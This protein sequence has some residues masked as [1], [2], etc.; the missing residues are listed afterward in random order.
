MTRRSPLQ[1]AATRKRRRERHVHE[2]DRP[3]T[4]LSEPSTASI[5]RPDQDSE[6]EASPSTRSNERVESSVIRIIPV[7]VTPPADRP[8][9]DPESRASL[10][11][12]YCIP[13]GH[14][15]TLPAQPSLPVR[16]ETV[17]QTPLSSLEIARARA[18]Q[19]GVLPVHQ[20]VQFNHDSIESRP[21]PR[22]PNAREHTVVHPPLSKPSIKFVESVYANIGQ[23]VPHTI[24]DQLR[25]H[26]P[27][28][29]ERVSQAANAEPHRKRQ[30]KG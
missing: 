19:N 8:V 16:T 18:F 30:L 1:R 3:T 28:T 14:S 6:Y 20:F 27:L 5:R 29:P 23:Q 9:F 17:R 22:P 15:S 13:L 24:K 21:W 4:T 12:S 25:Q 26:V 2:P 11:N 10:T 7:A